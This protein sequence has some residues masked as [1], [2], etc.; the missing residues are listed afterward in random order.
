MKNDEAHTIINE[1]TF[2]LPLDDCMT[3]LKFLI[4][5]FSE[6]VIS[7]WATDSQ[8]IF[9]VLRTSLTRDNSRLPINEALVCVP[10]GA[11]GN[12]SDACLVYFMTDFKYQCCSNFLVDSSYFQDHVLISRLNILAS[13]GSYLKLK[14][15]QRLTD[16]LNLGQLDNSINIK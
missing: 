4:P 3:S 9:Y 12:S 16:T 13:F 11:N 8:G 5:R 7:Y 14:S 2:D 10:L 1:Q 6:K 15:D